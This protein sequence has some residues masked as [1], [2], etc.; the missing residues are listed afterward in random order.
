[1]KDGLMD[2]GAVLRAA[3]EGNI[4]EINRDVV[5]DTLSKVAGCTYLLHCHQDKE[6]KKYENAEKTEKIEKKY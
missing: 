2:L 4:K 5:S 6:Q 3:K 1:M